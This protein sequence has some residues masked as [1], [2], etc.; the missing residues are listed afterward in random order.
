MSGRWH[1]LAIRPE[2]VPNDPVPSL[3]VSLPQDHLLEP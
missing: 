2:L 3:D 1:R